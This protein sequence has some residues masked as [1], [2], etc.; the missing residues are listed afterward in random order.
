MKHDIRIAGLE[1]GK[2]ID[3]RGVFYAPYDKLICIALNDHAIVG[4]A[5]GHSQFWSQ[6]RHYIPAHVIVWQR[7]GEGSDDGCWEVERVWEKNTGHKSKIVQ[8][9]GIEFA[10]YISERME[11]DNDEA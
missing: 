4:K 1:V 10:I 6:S 9:E 2:T 7:T 3:T 5:G 11:Q 8:A